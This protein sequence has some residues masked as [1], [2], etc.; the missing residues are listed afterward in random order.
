MAFTPQAYN[1]PYGLD[2]TQTRRILRGLLVIT[3]TT[4]APGGVL[5]ASYSAIKDASGQLVL[6]DSLNV[7]PDTAWFQSISGSGY[8]Y[9]YNKATGKV[10]IW[11]NS[12]TAQNP[13]AE[14]SA[15]AV[16]SGVIA[17]IVEFEFQWVRQ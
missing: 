2:G 13:S 10:Q 17:D 6:V 8:E 16:P 11:V 5:P 1:A 12:G 9:S 15:G 3:A 7:N 4:Y 14:L